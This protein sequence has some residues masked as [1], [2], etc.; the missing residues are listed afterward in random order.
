VDVLWSYQIPFPGVTHPS[1]EHWMPLTTGLIAAAFAVQRA[2]SGATETSFKIAQMPGLVIGALLA[3]LTYLVGR[4]LLPGGRRFAARAWQ[5]SRWVALGAALLVALNATLSYQS[6][7][8][9]S[10]SPFALI[11][12]WALAMAVRKPGYQGSYLSVG[13]LVALAY[14]TRADGLLLLIA[15]P[16][17]W[18]LPPLL[19]RRRLEFSTSSAEEVVREHQSKEQSMKDNPQMLAGPKLR[20]ILDLGVAFALVITP[21]LVRNYLAFGTPLPSSVLSQAWLSDYV[22]T[23]SYWSHPTWETWL[24]QGWQAILGQRVEALLHNGRVFL[25]STYPWGLLALPGLWLLRREWPFFPALI[26]TLVLFFGVALVF[27]VS[28]MSGTFYH[29]LGALMPFLALAAVYSIQQGVQALGRYRKLAGLILTAVT[30][31]LL[32][33]A[34]S[35]VL[36]ALPAIAERHQAEKEQFEAAAG[37]LAQY[38]VPGDVV[39]T[40]QPYTLNYASGHPTIVLPG[41]EPAN[42][43]WEAAQHY[44]ARYLVITQGFGQYPQ[45]LQEQPDSRFRLLEETE[46][47]MIYEIGG[48]HP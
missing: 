10:S 45:L 44:D 9:D 17:A 18:L 27:P 35:Q 19:P 42:A 46:T 31:A 13:L 37:W 38:A 20:T 26:Y 48:G 33:V 23:F 47:T 6:A 8:A 11:T 5:N 39:M 34:G 43:I 7:S 2:L 22:D 28:S 32:V 25:L 15:I 40:A 16:L 14:L 41:N 4:R 12:A 3:P 21:W 30:A 1:H 29:S 24:A 36:G